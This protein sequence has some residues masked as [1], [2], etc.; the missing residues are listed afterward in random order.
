MTLREVKLKRWAVASRFNTQGTLQEGFV[1]E[2]IIFKVC[3]KKENVKANF[4]K[5]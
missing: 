2:L 1:T 4:A 3:Q 5:Y